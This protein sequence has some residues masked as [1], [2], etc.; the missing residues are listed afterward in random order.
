M[1]NTYTLITSQTLGSNTATITLSSIP[2]TYNDLQL[3]LTAGND[4]VGTIFVRANGSSTAVYNGSWMY[5]T[6]SGSTAINYD[7]NDNG[8]RGYGGAQ[9]GTALS[10]GFLAANRIYIGNYSSTTRNKPMEWINEQ[11][12]NVTNNGL[13]GLGY[14]VWK[15]NT[16]I[17]SLTIVGLSDLGL[18]T[19]GTSVALYGIKNT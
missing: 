13:T 17:S 12:S 2:Q 3:I 14:N 18:M 5:G 6:G 19:T 7:N 11:S 1:A 8:Y 4:T 10:N 15:N 16:A 9:S